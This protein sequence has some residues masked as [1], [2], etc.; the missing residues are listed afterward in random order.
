MSTHHSTQ[1]PD[2][3]L[4]DTKDIE[5]FHDKDDAQP[6]PSTV[7]PAKPLGHGLCNKATKRF[8]HA[9]ACEQLG[10]DEEDLDASARPPRHKHTAHASNVSGGA[11]PPTLSSKNSFEILLAEEFSDNEKDGSFQSDDSSES[12]DGSTDL[13]SISN[14]EVQVE[15]FFYNLKSLF[16]VLLACRCPAK[17][18][19]CQSQPQWLQATLKE[20]VTQM[21]GC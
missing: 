15:L 17:E 13:E 19:G 3:S 6:L 12:D 18:D 1:N 20:G 9:V 4:K 21:Q 10:S 11:A 16:N 8:L 14:N 5:W 7:A 2:G